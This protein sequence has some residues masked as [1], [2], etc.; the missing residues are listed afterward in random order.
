MDPTNAGLL[1]LVMDARLGALRQV[2]TGPGVIQARADAG[3]AGVSFWQIVV[4]V[5]PFVEQLLAGQPISWSAVIQAI[6]A[7]FQPA[8]TPTPAVRQ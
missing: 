5:L 3:T 8:P 2:L 7:L 4:A 6:L 1:D